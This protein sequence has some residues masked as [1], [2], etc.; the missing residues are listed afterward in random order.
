MTSYFA[1]LVDPKSQ[2]YKEIQ[3]RMRPGNCSISGFLDKDEDLRE[4]VLRD[5][6]T[7][8]MLNITH[9]QIADKLES[10]VTIAQKK[11]DMG[12]EAIVE[13]KFKIEGRFYR[14]WQECPF[15]TFLK[16]C[17][18][19]TKD[20]AIENITT[21]QKIRFSELIIHLIRDH[22]F[23]EGNVYYRLDP[24]EAIKCLELEPELMEK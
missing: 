17:P 15:Y 10:L 16:T 6:K 2:E 7:L 11:W 14:G 8:E 23:F 12:E 3:E 9:N 4:V 21:G 5:N 13:G 1:E 22:H 18:Q 20:F 19:I 24:V